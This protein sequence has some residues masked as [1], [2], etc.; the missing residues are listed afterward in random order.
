[1]LLGGQGAALQ[2]LAGGQ[3][4]HQPQREQHREGDRDQQVGE[5][6]LTVEDARTGR[7]VSP[8]GAPGSAKPYRLHPLA[9]KPL[10]TPRRHRRCELSPTVSATSASRSPIG[11]SGPVVVSLP[12]WRS[13]SASSS[14]PSTHTKAER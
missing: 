11:R 14:P 10:S 9:P 12:V 1:D 7:P 8:W 5:Q 6:H 4:A 13:V 3:H 2:P